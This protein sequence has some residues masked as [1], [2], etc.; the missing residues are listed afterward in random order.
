MK[1]WKNSR[2]L[3]RKSSLLSCLPL[4]QLS[5]V[6]RSKGAVGEKDADGFEHVIDG[7]KVKALIE[8]LPFALTDEQ[9]HAAQE[10]LSDMA[11]PRIMNRLLLG[12]VG[13]GKTAVAAVALAA[14]ADSPRDSIIS[15]QIHS[16]MPDAQESSEGVFGFFARVS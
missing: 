1:R 11:A 6:Q 8:A 4:V 15:K 9:N 16:G 3:A 13:T 12:D 10:I 7:P 2:A 14:A 5:S